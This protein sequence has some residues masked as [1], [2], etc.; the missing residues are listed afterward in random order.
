VGSSL[1]RITS[2]RQLAGVTRGEEEQHAV[3]GQEHVRGAGFDAVGFQVGEHEGLRVRAALE[4]DPGQ[5][6]DRA[7]RTI[8]TDHIAGAH[9]LDRAVAMSQ[10]CRHRV[11]ALMQGGQFDAAVHGHATVGEVFGEDPFGLRLREE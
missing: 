4:P 11:G 5:L 9:L 10:R 7:V 6:A 2:R 8:A 3:V 1:G